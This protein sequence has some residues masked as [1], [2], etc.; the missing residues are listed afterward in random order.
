MLSRFKGGGTSRN[1]SAALV[2]LMLMAA[3]VCAQEPPAIDAIQ[4][5]IESGN[6]DEASRQL[7]TALAARTGDA[8]LLNLRGVVH[9]ERKEYQLARQDFERAVTLAPDL[10][11][12][13]RNLGRAC[14]MMMAGDAGASE[15][16][17]SAWRRVL[18]S[19]AGDPEARFSLAAVYESEGKYSASLIEIK[20][21]PDQEAARAPA[22]ILE[23][24]DL[25]GLG[26]IEEATGLAR[27]L[28]NAA[29]LS[30]SDVV[31]ILPL[32]ASPK[33]AAVRIAL[34]EALDARALASPAALRQLV[35]AYESVPR[36]GDARRLLERMAS[37]DRNNPQHLLELARV[38]YL[39]HDLEGSLGYLGHARDL[40]PGDAQVHF[41]FGMVLEEMK[42]PFEARRSVEKALA[43]APG[44]PDYSYALATILLAT[45][46]ASDAIPLLKTYTH[47]RP[48]DAR[49]RLALGIAYFGASQYDECRAEVRGIIDD[50]DTGGAA[51][52]LLGRVERISE[53]FDEAATA[54]DRAIRRMPSFAPAYT[55]LARVRLEQGRLDD[56]RAAIGRAIALDPHDFQA[57]STLLKL[58]SRT[59]DPRLQEQY[60]LVRKLDAARNEK[61]AELERLMLRGI[62]VKP[63]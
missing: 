21:L 24:A 42:L 16:A 61:E 10:I 30:E 23:C 32:L 8:G 1:G 44:N 29:E 55:E 25:A 33:R 37:L 50:S 13:W 49:G 5:A 3:T 54:L 31:S 34:L 41:L 4:Q 46:N 63:Y 62:E 45:K 7:S 57:N 58:Y 48:R 12:A 27:G 26:R 40:T 28:S 36:L 43:L 59:K 53:N 6:L 9:A 2:V 20:K 60:A 17:V 18:A 38:A 11:P 15:C 52:Y 19:E 35:S 51:A 47:A 56:T 22:L 14:Q 39:Q